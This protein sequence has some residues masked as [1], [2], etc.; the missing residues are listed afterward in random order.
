MFSG[1]AAGLYRITSD[2]LS[3]NPNL[4]SRAGGTG[5][6]LISHFVDTIYVTEAQVNAA[7]QDPISARQG[8]LISVLGGFHRGFY[9]AIDD[10]T[11]LD[12]ED[13]DPRGSGDLVEYISGFGEVQVPTTANV[14]AGTVN[15][16]VP[17]GGRIRFGES[18]GNATFENIHPQP[19]ADNTIPFRWV[20]SVPTSFNGNAIDSGSTD[21]LVRRL[22][23]RVAANDGWREVQYSFELEQATDFAVSGGEAAED[24]N[25][26]GRPLYARQVGDDWTFTPEDTRA[27]TWVPGY[28]KL[29]GSFYIHNGVTYELRYNLDNIIRTAGDEAPGES[30]GRAFG[31]T[32]T[33]VTQDANLASTIFELPI[34]GFGPVSETLMDDTTVRLSF[35]DSAGNDVEVQFN[36]ND[37]EQ[38][39]FRPTGTNNTQARITIENRFIADRG[40]FVAFTTTPTLT[41]EAGTDNATITDVTNANR[42]RNIEHVIADNVDGLDLHTEGEINRFNTENHITSLETTRTGVTFNTDTIAISDPGTQADLAFGNFRNSANTADRPVI[43]RTDSHGDNT[44]LILQDTEY[45][46]FRERFGIGSDS[47]G[48]GSSTPAQA[49]AN[50]HISGRHLVTQITQPATGDTEI[51]ATQFVVTNVREKLNPGTSFIPTGAA[52]RITAERIDDAS[53][54]IESHHRFQVL[55]HYGSTAGNSAGQHA[56][57]WF[58]QVLLHRVIAGPGGQGSINST[59]TLWSGGDIVS[60]NIEVSF[61]G[62]DTPVGETNS[63]V[64]LNIVEQGLSHPNIDSA[65]LVNQVYAAIEGQRNTSNVIGLEFVARNHHSNVSANTAEPLGRVLIGYDNPNDAGATNGGG[66]RL[67]VGSLRDTTDSSSTS[68]R[69][70]I[71]NGY[72]AGGVRN[73]LA[74]DNESVDNQGFYGRTFAQQGA[75]YISTITGAATETR[76]ITTPTGE[77]IVIPTGVSGGGFDPNAGTIPIATGTTL[78]NNGNRTTLTDGQLLYKGTT[79]NVTWRVTDDTQMSND[80]SAAQWLNLLVGTNGVYVERWRFNT[81]NPA[82]VSG[83]IWQS[84]ASDPTGNLGGGGARLDFAPTNEFAAL[85]SALPTSGTLDEQFSATSFGMAADTDIVWRIIDNNGDA[86]GGNAADEGSRTWQGL[87]T[88]AEGSDFQWVIGDAVFAGATGQNEQPTANGD[89]FWRVQVRRNVTNTVSSGTAPVDQTLSGRGY[90]QFASATGDNGSFAPFTTFNPSVTTV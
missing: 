37:G 73:L 27:T 30:V 46:A 25:R 48:M 40:G 36:W 89:V 19:I 41:S 68:P 39:L 66:F 31:T 88:Q 12:P 2:H 90:F 21:E 23:S 11:A 67:R 1:A 16:Y 5:Y 10:I 33:S 7:T 4:I 82:N 26:T 72:A 38:V 57:Q 15:I 3:V 49:S 22:R 70:W 29:I 32:L 59:T 58:D 47:T 43:F 45:A 17:P 42:Y 13:I 74:A 62:I 84:L 60:P 81:A 87:G 78:G 75:L 80:V 8:D 44:E 61:L 28:D 18:F 14:V 69:S 63:T 77:A 50:A 52:R 65:A 34:G 35:V 83:F 9:R 55:R 53:A 76:T 64:T 56:E 79:T 24:A 6:E 51:P 20:D 71:L 54:G 85:Q 86:V